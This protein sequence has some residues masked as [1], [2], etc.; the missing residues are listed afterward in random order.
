MSSYFDCAAGVAF[1]GS[2]ADFQKSFQSVKRKGESC[3][4]RADSSDS[5]FALQETAHEIHE[6]IGLVCRRVFMPTWTGKDTKGPSVHGRDEEDS[7]PGTRIASPS[8]DVRSLYE[9]NSWQATVKDS[10]RYPRPASGRHRL[11]GRR[12]ARISSLSAGRFCPP[13]EG[14][15]KKDS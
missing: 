12:V 14:E 15:W 4:L 9:G 1:L 11:P 8:R 6:P 7:R 3:L 5:S 2:G 13:A 10:S